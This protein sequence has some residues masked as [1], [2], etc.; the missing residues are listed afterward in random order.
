VGSEPTRLLERTTGI[1]GAAALDPGS[2]PLPGPLHF[3]VFG[4]GA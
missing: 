3:F 2:S 1:R 4:F